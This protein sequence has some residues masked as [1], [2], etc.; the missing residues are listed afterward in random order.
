MNEAGSPSQLGYS[1]IFKQTYVDAFVDPLFE[2][3]KPWLRR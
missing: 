2:K 1:R 3:E